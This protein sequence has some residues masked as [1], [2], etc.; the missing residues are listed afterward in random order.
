MGYGKTATGLGGL[1][2]EG[3]KKGGVDDRWREKG[4]DREEWKVITAGTV[5]QYT[6]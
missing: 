5:H 6:N 3:C 4:A 1:R 2:N